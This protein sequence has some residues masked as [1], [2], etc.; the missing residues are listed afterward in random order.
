LFW[1]LRGAGGSFGVV[2]QFVYEVHPHPETMPV[3]VPTYIKDLKD[4]ER[5]VAIAE[6]GVFDVQLSKNFFFRPFQMGFLTE[7]MVSEFQ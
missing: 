4:I 3:M 1:A 7:N 6:E 2:T 5:L